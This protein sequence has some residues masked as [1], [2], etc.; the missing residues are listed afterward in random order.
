[1][2]VLVSLHLIFGG[3]GLDLL[4]APVEGSLHLPIRDDIG[5]Q[6]S[7]LVSLHLIFGS[8]GLD[9]LKAPVEG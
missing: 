7:V 5:G 2:L 8:L 4:K 3:L 6:M 9:L 1:M